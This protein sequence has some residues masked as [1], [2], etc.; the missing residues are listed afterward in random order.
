MKCNYLRNENNSVDRWEIK[1]V[2]GQL[3]FVPVSEEEYVKGTFELYDMEIVTPKNKFINALKRGDYV[4][5][6]DY[7][8]FLYHNVFHYENGVLEFFKFDDESELFM[9]PLRLKREETIFLGTSSSPIFK[10]FIDTMPHY[11]DLIVCRKGN[12]LDIENIPPSIANFM[13]R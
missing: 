4:I 3:K 8:P 1:L 2:D 9:A 10:L 5:G 12:L 7:N 6:V 13:K 11:D